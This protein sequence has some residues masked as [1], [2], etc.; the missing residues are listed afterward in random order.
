M[1]V[2]PVDLAILL[3]SFL[4]TLLSPIQFFSDKY[5]LAISSIPFVVMIT[6]APELRI[7]SHLCFNI[8]HSFYLI[9]SNSFGFS[10]LIEI[11]IWSLNL[12]RLK[13]RQAILA[14]LTEV[15]IY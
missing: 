7:K 1:T 12:L 13:S 2:A 11:P 4:L 15:G 6:L 8:S 5:L 10:I 9:F 14:F 3:K